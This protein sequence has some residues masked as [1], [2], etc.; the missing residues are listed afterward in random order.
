MHQIDPT[1]TYIIIGALIAYIAATALL[2]V[3]LRSRDSSDFMVAARSM[4]A[5]VVGILM[6]SEFVGAKSTIGTA[7]AA[8][9]S[10]AAAMWTVLSAAIGFPL[11]GIF[12][13]KKLYTSGEFTIS[14]AVAKRYGRSTQITVSLIMIY[15]LLL[16]NV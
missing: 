11:F 8:F 6:M 3:K 16:V 7:Q 15:A 13:A 9:E 5:I 2:T 14:G 1:V 10:G 12:L 4:P